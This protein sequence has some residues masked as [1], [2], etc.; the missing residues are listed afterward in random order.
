MASVWMVK[1]LPLKYTISK[2]LIWH[3]LCCKIQVTF[4]EVKLPLANYVHDAC[5][6]L[7]CVWR[8]LPDWTTLHAALLTDTQCMQQGTPAT[9]VCKSAA[10][11]GQ[12]RRKCPPCRSLGPR[13]EMAEAAAGAGF[14]VRQRIR[15]WAQICW[16]KL[17]SRASWWTGQIFSRGLQNKIMI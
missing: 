12:G 5:I 8:D 3:R 15:S 16:K 10:Y 7:Q 1:S 11:P 4:R 17:A 9:W 13:M 6:L 14:R 2:S